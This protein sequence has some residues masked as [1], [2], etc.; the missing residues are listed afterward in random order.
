MTKQGPV[1]GRGTIKRL[2]SLVQEWSKGLQ[3]VHQVA[4]TKTAVQIQDVRLSSRY[5]PFKIRG[6]WV[7]KTTNE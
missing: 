6:A 7:A 2:G 1:V 3:L 4:N 5:F